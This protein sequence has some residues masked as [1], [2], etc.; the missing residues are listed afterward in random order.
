[1]FLKCQCLRP[2]SAGPEEGESDSHQ[3]ISISLGAGSV[4]VYL[5][6]HVCKL[7][8]GHTRDSFVPLRKRLSPT[9][10]I[11]SL[12]TMGSS[13]GPGQWGPKSH[14]SNPKGLGSGRA[15]PPR[16]QPCGEKGPSSG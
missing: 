13:L 11:M 9:E 8:C 10:T 16:Q 2:E 14:P 7:M 15:W 4:D 6:V 5:C 1:M 12:F 3:T